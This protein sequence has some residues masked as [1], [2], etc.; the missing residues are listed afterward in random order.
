MIEG[1]NFEIGHPKSVYIITDVVKAGTI[2]AIAI[3]DDNKCESTT[4]RD[5]QVAFGYSKFS[6]L[7]D[8]VVSGLVRS[9]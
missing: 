8:G 6:L 5:R 3:D 4:L 1:L 9:N 7:P 2:T